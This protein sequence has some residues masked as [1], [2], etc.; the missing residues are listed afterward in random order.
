LTTSSSEREDNDVEEGELL[1]LSRGEMLVEEFGVD[2]V[3][4]D[5]RRAASECRAVVAMIKEKLRP[6]SR[7]S[8]EVR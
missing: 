5:R 6:E 1:G 7:D 8:S 4:A 3:V 2:S